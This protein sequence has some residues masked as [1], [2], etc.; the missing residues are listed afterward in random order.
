MKKASSWAVSR[1]GAACGRHR[2]AAL[3]PRSATTAAGAGPEERQ[4]TAGA[5]QSTPGQ[6]I[7]PRLPGARPRRTGRAALLHRA[8]R[9]AAVPQRG[10]TDLLCASCL[11]PPIHTRPRPRPSTPRHQGH[12]QTTSTFAASARASLQPGHL[13]WPSAGTYRGARLPPHLLVVCVNLSALAPRALPRFL[14]CLR[15]PDS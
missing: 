13:P 15:P 6:E 12:R 10:P 14:A 4:D 3:P 11:Q 7:K 1:A 5:T 8:L 9:S 2:D